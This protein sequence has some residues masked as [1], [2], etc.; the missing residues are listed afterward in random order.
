MGF[1]LEP[2]GE[3]V[4][5][6]ITAKEHFKVTHDTDGN[7]ELEGPKEAWPGLAELLAGDFLEADEL[8]K[9]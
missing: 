4:R 6:T 2:I 3:N 9:E 7:I 8:E 1:M 5:L